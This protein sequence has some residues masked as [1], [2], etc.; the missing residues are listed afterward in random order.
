MR[1]KKLGNKGKMIFFNIL[2][3]KKCSLKEETVK[4]DKKSPNLLNLKKINKITSVWALLSLI[5]W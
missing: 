4:T 1:R 3:L 2:G 5:M